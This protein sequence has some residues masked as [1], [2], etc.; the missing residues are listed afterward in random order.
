M[1]PFEKKHLKLQNMFLTPD[2]I[3]PQIMAIFKHFDSKALD[4]ALRFV[5]KQH[6][7]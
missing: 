4:T 3:R 7:V 2:M 6:Y 1:I 5:N